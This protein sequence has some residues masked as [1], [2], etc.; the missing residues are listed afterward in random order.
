M[1]VC[2][3]SDSSWCGRAMTCLG[4]SSQEAGGSAIEVENSWLTCWELDEQVASPCRAS[5]PHG[6]KGILVAPAQ[7]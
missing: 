6:E 2:E 1:C 4:R 3:L 7:D 5:L